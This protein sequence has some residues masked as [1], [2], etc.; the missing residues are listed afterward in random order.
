M[1]MSVK[2]Q[3]QPE[4]ATKSGIINYEKHGSDKTSPT[5]EN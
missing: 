1:Y 2:N 3:T 5:Y 4:K